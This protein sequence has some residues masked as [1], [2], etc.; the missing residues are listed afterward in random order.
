MLKTNGNELI[1]ESADVCSL[2]RPCDVTGLWKSTQFLL[3]FALRTLPLVHLLCS[4]LY[5]RLPRRILWYREKM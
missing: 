2:F 3:E 1:E 4:H 5:E